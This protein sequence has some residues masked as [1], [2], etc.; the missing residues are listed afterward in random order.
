M[1]IERIS[2]DQE[3]VDHI[4]NHSVSPEE[5]EEVLFNDTDLPLIMRGKEGKYLAYGK[6]NGG[7]FLLVVW[8]FRYRK[9]KIITARDM[10]KKEKQLYKRRRR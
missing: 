5:V 6:T 3:T 4:S 2:W 10:S 1:K 7:R 8:A 9:T